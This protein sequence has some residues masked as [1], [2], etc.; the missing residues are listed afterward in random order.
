M[1]ISRKSPQ[2]ELAFVRLRE[3]LSKGERGVPVALFIPVGF[4]ALLMVFVALET[5]QRIKSLASPMTLEGEPAK[6][7]SLWYSI[8]PVE[9]GLLIAGNDGQSFNVSATGEGYQEFEN[10]L[11]ERRKQLISDLTLAN[12]MDGNSTFVILSVDEQLTYAQ[13]RPVVYSLA[14]AGI[15]KYGFEGK[16]LNN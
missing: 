3:N 11:M 9:D 1:M 5:N 6:E 14:K 16:I 8:A 7:T 2:I 4:I 15:T 12:R 13:V 10:H